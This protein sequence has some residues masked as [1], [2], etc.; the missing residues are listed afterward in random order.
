MK[1]L[2]RLLIIPLIFL[3]VA[4]FLLSGCG[5]LGGLYRNLKTEL[6]FFRERIKSAPSEVQVEHRP[7]YSGGGAMERGWAGALVLLGVAR[8]FSVRERRRR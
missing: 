2:S 5:L 4:G 7:N 3:G 6:D 8:W 1:R